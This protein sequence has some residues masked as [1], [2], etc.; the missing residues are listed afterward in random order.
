[1]GFARIPALSTLGLL[2]STYAKK[3]ACLALQ[4]HSLSTTT[5]RTLTCLKKVMAGVLQVDP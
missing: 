2:R 5:V 4:Y 3:K 1:M